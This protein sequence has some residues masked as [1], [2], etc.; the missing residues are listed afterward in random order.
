MA[1]GDI[2]GL[3]FIGGSKA[4]D[5]LIKQHPNPH[6]LKVFLQLE[7]NNMAIYLSDLFTSKNKQP[8]ETALTETITGTLSFN[9]Q[10]CTA[11]KLLM[12]PTEYADVFAKA[13]VE[14]VEALS[15]GLPWEQSDGNLSKV[16]PLPN[17]KRVQYMQELIAD[18]VENGAKVINKNGGQLVG[19]PESTLMNPAVLYPVT[20]DMKIYHEEQFGPVIPIAPYDDIETVLQYGQSGWSAQQVS[21]FTDVDAETSATVIDRFSSVFGK[22]NL[23][24]QW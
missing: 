15:V 5:D 21:L 23:N 11:L 17:S 10:R 4:A 3:A 20:S 16:T 6:R 24:S 2:D 12:V 19:G 7:A 1:T 18:A 8:L 14:K 9:G 13:L 22:I